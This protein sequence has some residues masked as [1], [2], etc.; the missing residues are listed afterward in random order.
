MFFEDLD[1]M[2]AWVVAVRDSRG[3]FLAGFSAKAPSL[4]DV[5]MVEAFA[6]ACR[7]G[8]EDGNGGGVLGHPSIL[9]VIAYRLLKL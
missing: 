6:V 2:V 1:C 8:F 9:K 5:Q 7:V 3:I 4:L